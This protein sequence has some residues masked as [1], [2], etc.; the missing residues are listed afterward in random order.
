[1][2]SGRRSTQDAMRA[3]LMAL[4]ALCAAGW[5][6]SSLRADCTI[7]CDAP[8]ILEGFEVANITGDSGFFCSQLGR[9]CG[10]PVLRDVSY[11]LDDPTCDPH[12]QIACAITA[13]SEWL[14]P[15]NGSGS[16]FQGS[17]IKAGWLLDDANC[18]LSLSGTL[19][20]D[21]GIARAH[22]EAACGDPPTKVLRAIMCQGSPCIQETQLPLDVSGSALCQPRPTGCGEGDAGAGLCCFGPG[23]ASPPNGAPPGFGV[24]GTNARFVYQAE[25]VGHPS[26]PGAASWIGLSGLGRYW[27]HEFATRLVGI[28][29]PAVVWLITPGGTFRRF[30][31]SNGDGFYEDTAPS[32]EDRTLEQEGGGWTLTSLDG[33]RTVFGPDGS[34]QSTT[35]RLG[36]AWIASHAG[37]LLERVEFPDGRQE[38]FSYVGGRLESVQQKGL[39]D[40]GTQ[41][42]G[43]PADCTSATECRTWSFTWNGSDLAVSAQ[44]VVHSRGR[45]EAAE[46][47]VGSVVIV[48][49][50]PGVECLLAKQ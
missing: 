18:G 9:T 38:V 20:T 10:K 33:T 12:G 49:V 13:E 24:P 5:P 4:A 39:D 31:D 32:D 36:N 43:M 1:M 48:V 3:W 37:G 27:I 26:S 50:E 2:R 47:G 17:S 29:D 30:V 23:G 16:C 34:W 14:F 15:T 41:G 11:T 44:H 25:G 46:G 42:A 28:A 19:D 45:W 7:F 6:L 22:Y 35:D 21:V 40:D 8:T